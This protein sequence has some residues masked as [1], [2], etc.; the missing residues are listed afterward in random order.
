MSE[1]PASQ[2]QYLHSL[3]SRLVVSP[4]TGSS[5]VFRLF[6]QGASK[7]GTRPHAK[8]AEYLA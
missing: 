6:S 2:I 4:L 1:I 3:G 5:R 8:F 7:L